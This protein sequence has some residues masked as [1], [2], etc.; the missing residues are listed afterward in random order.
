[1]PLIT[2]DDSLSVGVRAMDDQHK[3]LIQILNDL[4]EAMAKGLARQ[5]TG[6]MLEKLANYTREHFSA[7]ESIMKRAGYP[8]L[9]THHAMHVELNLKVEDYLA[10][11]RNGDI[12]LSIDLVDFL[13]NWLMT[14]I[15]KQDRDYGPWLNRLGV[16]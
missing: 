10:R 12:G 15:Q 6:P 8:S 13:R 4:H 7:E 3:G 9:D 11:F 2:W 16:K 14:H 5:A 1:V